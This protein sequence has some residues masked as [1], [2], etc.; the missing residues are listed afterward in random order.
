MHDNK[1]LTKSEYDMLKEAT[2]NILFD[3]TKVTQNNAAK[4]RLLDV[5]SCY[6]PFKSSKHA[7]LFNVTGTTT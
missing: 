7:N 6:N 3:E 5:G 4:P 1:H 2:K